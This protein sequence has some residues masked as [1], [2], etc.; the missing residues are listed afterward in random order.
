[1]YN[2]NG[3]EIL[4]DTWIYD[5]FGSINY[6]KVSR[7]TCILLESGFIIES[8]GKTLIC[9]YNKKINLIFIFILGINTISVTRDYVEDI[10]DPTIFAIPPECH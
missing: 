3:K 2:Y 4:T 5:A 1:M 8:A 10:V 9:F 6:Q 7:N